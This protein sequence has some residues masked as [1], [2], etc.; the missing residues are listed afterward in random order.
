MKQGKFRELR[1]EKGFTQKELSEML[2][3]NQT[4]V[5]HWELGTALPDVKTLIKLAE[6][7]DV[8][9]DF[10]LGFSDYYYPDRI[11]TSSLSD[12]E[13]ELVDT[14]RRMTKETQAITL[15]TVHS[16]AGDNERRKSVLNKR[17]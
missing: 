8:S 10:I 9:I 15:D 17:A 13:K 1:K 3:L 12:D 2:N 5:S 7:Y 14:F 6:I 11:P 4:T 16:L